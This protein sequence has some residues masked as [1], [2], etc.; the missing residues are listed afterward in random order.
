MMLRP[1]RTNFANRVNSGMPIRRIDANRNGTRLEVRHL[2]LG[3]KNAETVE[4]HLPRFIGRNANGKE[5][6]DE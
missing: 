4:S 1:I 3:I 2:R 6:Y 5:A